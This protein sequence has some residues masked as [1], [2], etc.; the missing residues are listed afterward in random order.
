MIEFSNI[1]KLLLTVLPKNI[2]EDKPHKALAILAVIEGIESGVYTENKIYFNSYFKDLF[3]KY[4][5][6]YSRPQDSNRP[7]NPFF[8][9]RSSS[10]WKLQ[11]LKGKKEEL[12]ALTSV[13]S[14]KDLLNLVD[15][16]H[17]DEELF[18]Y[19]ISDTEHCGEVKRFIIG[20]LAPYISSPTP[21][22]LEIPSKFPHEQQALE[23]IIP[24][25]AKQVEFIPN[26]ELHDSATNEYLEC[27]LIA[28]C[29]SFIAIV[30]LKHW[31]GEIEILPNNWHVHGKF[32]P[33]PHKANTYKCK[34]LKSH[35]E[36]TFP[37]IKIPWV[38]SVVVLT[39]PKAIVYNQ[40]L[41]KK[42]AKNP[43]FAGT[44]DLV[45]YFQFRISTE[46]KILG[47]NDREKIADSLWNLVDGPKKKGLHIPGYELLDNITQTPGR[48]ELLAR[49][50][51]LELQSV[52]RLRI[53]TPDSTLPYNQQE[54][55]RKQAFNTLKTLDQLDYHP[56]LLRVEALPNEDDLIIEV[57]D[58]SNEGTLADVLHNKGKF[59][60]EEAVKI[61][62]GIVAGLSVLHEKAIVH[63]DLRPENILMQGLLPVLMN[64]DYTYIPDHGPE[65]TVF[66]DPEN[67]VASPFLAPELY[68][69]GQFSEATDLFSVGVIFYTLLCGKP[70]FDNSLELLNRVDSLTE[71]NKDCLREVVVNKTIIPLISSLV[72]LNRNQRPQNT[73]DIETQLEEQLDD[74]NKKAPA[75]KSND[76]LAPG[77]SHDVYVID[78][79]IGQGREAQVYAGRGFNGNEIAL[80]LYFHEIPRERINAEQKH[81]SLVN[82]PFVLHEY[83]VHVWSNGRFFLVTNLIQGPS[84]RKLIKNGR[85]PTIETFR[86]VATCL[87]M[88]LQ[89]LHR[90]PA[91]ETPLLHNDIKPDN[92]LLTVQGDPVLLDFGT[93]CSPHIGL[94]QGTDYYIAPDLLRKI[95]YEFC[96]SGDLFALGVTLFEW[97]LGR[98][99]YVGV[100]T[101]DS[102]PQVTN[103]ERQIEIPA[104]LFDW[105][106]QAVQPLRNDRFADI[107]RM[108]EVFDT[109]W[110]P[111]EEQNEQFLPEPEKT[112]APHESLLPLK[113]E[114]VA[115]TE[116]NDF[117]RYLNSLHNATAADEGALAETQALS[118]HFGQIHVPL[119]QTNYILERLTAPEGIHVF[120]T[121]HAG[122]GKSTIGLEL[123]KQLHGIPPDL[124][125]D[126]PL[127][128]DESIEYH[129]HTIHIVKDM[130]ELSAEERVSKI[131]SVLQ[132]ENSE[133]WFII[134]NT[135]TLLATWKILAEELGVDSYDVEGRLLDTLGSADPRELTLLDTQLSIINLAGT[136]NIST[137]IDVLKRIL[138]H[139][140]WGKCS[141]CQVQVSCP[142][143]RNIMA[144]L[145][146]KERVSERISWIYRRLKEYGTRLTMRQL[147]GHLAYSLTGGLD[148]SVIHG[149]AAAPNPPDA[150]DF[151]FS[152]LFFGYK[153]GKR[154]ELV[155]R[156][157]AIRH[158]R[159]LECGSKPFPALDKIFWSM[160]KG[161]LPHLPPLLT[162]LLEPFQKDSIFRVNGENEKTCQDRGALRRLYYIFGEFPSSL[163]SFIPQFLESEVL[164]DMEQW[165]EGNGPQTMYK[166]KLLRKILR[167]LQ[168]QYTGFLLSENH[169]SN[170]LYIALRRRNEG[171]RQSVQLLLAEIPFSSF[172]LD[173][174]SVN[175]QFEP[176]R[177]VLELRESNSQNSLELD[178]PFLDFVLLRDRGE[179]GQGLHPGYRDRL[180]RFK[181]RLLEKQKNTGTG[182][183]LNLLEMGRSGRLKV[184]TLE[185]NDQQLQVT[186]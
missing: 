184:R 142:I 154:N 113:I 75:K 17:L 89:A 164:V 40:S 64:F 59:S 127:K 26:F 167:V 1:E 93:A 63:R 151:F 99:P 98:R 100:P 70:P 107:D 183:Q 67:L 24:L 137:C 132:S 25:L 181:S 129:G 185:I 160:E 182:T 130:S 38:D 71:E 45:H 43:T 27:D 171:Y 88:A 4:F 121:G 123:Y 42:A 48:L 37:F 172:S 5:I 116:E 92:I 126:R 140:G 145:A 186:S 157:A 41:P 97:L 54:K 51:G 73:N 179:L 58:W 22:A 158:I 29:S 106:E 176:K 131:R 16:A 39:N 8:H 178:L 161:E 77:T 52:K 162:P 109:I 33:D 117:V 96:E 122:D 32:P 175:E 119:P 159:K 111:P 72:L 23:A 95:D 31:G 65:Y 62:L 50:K 10:F 46:D 69:D 101:V 146:A 120:L 57:S 53:F 104:A 12:D 128:E 87:L 166:S 108:Q 3:K 79:L 138:E 144:L 21:R 91:R 103:E 49:V 168:E 165:Q 115:H 74:H 124:P 85:I 19:L 143:R 15:Y 47:P 35:L 155:G 141:S 136:D 174:K 81:L 147:T 86:H 34:V 66:H 30:E 112:P 78:S 150:M 55:Q 90:D 44:D 82:S 9:L 80:K 6:K 135:G 110:L 169:A 18:S 114:E 105:L 134:S 170:S 28:I 20:A 153:E 133:R 36:N 94:Y 7:V 125:L 163:S 180:E 149:Q 152:D 177:S 14:P 102:I 118:K 76:P 13:G 83:G 139:Q 61:I 148:C 156:M 56:N 60:E 173:W 84:L 2:H 68:T 11:P